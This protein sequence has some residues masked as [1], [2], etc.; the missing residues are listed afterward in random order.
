MK[1]I[2]LVMTGGT[3]GSMTNGDTINTSRKTAS[4]LLDLFQ[5]YYSKAN[6]VQFKPLQLAPIHSENLQADFWRDLIIAIE[7]ENLKAFDGVIV[8]HGTD[9]L[10]FSAAMLGLYFHQL[11]I[12]LLLVSSHL[13]LEHPE[14]NGVNNFICAVDYIMQQQ[15]AAALVPYQNPGQ[16]MEVHLATRLL[17]C[18][19]LSC[20]FVSVQ[21]KPWMRYQEG[22]FFRVDEKRH[23]NHHAFTLSPRLDKKIL[24]IKPYPGLDYRCF[25]LQQVDCVLHDLYHSGT[26]CATDPSDPHS[27]LYFLRRCQTE[28]IPLFLAPIVKQSI[29][30]QSSRQLQDHGGEFIC[31]MPLEAAY[32]KLLLALGNFDSPWDI[33]HFLDCNIAGEIISGNA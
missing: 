5:K 10:A 14:A 18:L 30:Y 4:T 21:D 2:L 9:T 28:R 1:N 25:N 27:L 19:P 11:E 29:L 3:I 26:A 7:S 31:N 32:A 33:R 16:S 20:D 6:N 8:T 15:P 17:S 13:P 12:P 23:E 24:L 22:E